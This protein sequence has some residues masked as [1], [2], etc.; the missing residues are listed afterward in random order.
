MGPWDVAR[1]STAGWEF[2][3]SEQIAPK[4][5]ITRECEVFHSDPERD[6]KL[7]QEKCPFCHKP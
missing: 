3:A 6:T 7:N 2:R 1:V 5:T 4:I